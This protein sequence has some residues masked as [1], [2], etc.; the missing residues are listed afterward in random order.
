MFKTEGRGRKLFFIGLLTLALVAVSAAC[1]HS[2]EEIHYLK[3][4]F[5]RRF[6]VQEA[7][8]ASAIELIKLTILALPLALI[9]AVCIAFLR[10][11]EH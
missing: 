11:A 6:T 3:S 1:L 8:Y 9:I 5:P 4:F 10:R 7:F 2:L